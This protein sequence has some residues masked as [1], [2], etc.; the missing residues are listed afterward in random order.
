MSNGFT[1]KPM[2]H[3]NNTAL[4]RQQQQEKDKDGKKIQTQDNHKLFVLCRYTAQIIQNLI[5]FE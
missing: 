4:M 2:K 3:L 5:T 1:R